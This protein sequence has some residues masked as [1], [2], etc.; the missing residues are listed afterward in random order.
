MLNNQYNELNQ[1]NQTEYNHYN[2]P[3]QE[4]KVLNLKFK[5]KYFLLL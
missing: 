5:F 2:Q 4:L 1:L 3:P